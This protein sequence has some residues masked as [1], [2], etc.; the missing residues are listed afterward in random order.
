MT[1]IKCVGKDG[2]EREFYYSTEEDT[3]DHVWMFRVYK[4]QNS[5]GD[6]G[7]EVKYKP[8]SDF[9]WMQA[10]IYHH[11]NQE[12]SGKGIPEVIIPE[13]SRNRKVLIV[14]SP[15]QAQPTE[16]EENIFRTPDATKMWQRLVNKEI[17][18]Y[19]SNADIFVLLGPTE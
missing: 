16:Y 18:V 8:I 10:G 17:A 2:V 5:E 6:S 3:L 14:S 9:V 13:V 1:P 15:S 12:Y 7:F 11:G 4:N 19:N